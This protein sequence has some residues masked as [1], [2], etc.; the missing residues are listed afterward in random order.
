MDVAALRRRGTTHHD[1]AVTLPAAWLAAVLSD[2]DAQV[3]DPGHVEV[4]LHLPADGPVLVSGRLRAGFEVPC[5]RC[6]EPAQVTADPALQATFI[7]ERAP[8]DGADL[9]VDDDDPEG[10]LGLSADDLDTWSYDGKTVD[11]GPMLA[12]QVKVAYPMRALC[13]RG[14]ACRGLCSNCGANLNEQEDAP[15]CAACGH[16]VAAPG[17]AAQAEETGADSPLA[18]ALRKLQLPD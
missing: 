6:L 8:A 17:G 7:V 14:E 11:L 4:D 2:T 9:M 5:G 18:A 3:R 13:W 16:P 10:G 15:R 12:E 1:V